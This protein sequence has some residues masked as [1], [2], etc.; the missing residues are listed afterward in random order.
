ML[1]VDD[2]QDAADT[3]G[4]LLELS[5]YEVRVAYDPGVALALLDDFVPH[6]AVLDIGLPGMSGYELAAR[7]RAHRNGTRL[8]P[9]RADRLRHGRGHGAGAA[10]PAST[11]TWSSRR[12]PRRCW[13]QPMDPQDIA[14]TPT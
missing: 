2:N 8:L 1:L 6:V 5:G 9:G 13:S 14:R 3:A 7:V 10:R 4:A 12:R 11:S